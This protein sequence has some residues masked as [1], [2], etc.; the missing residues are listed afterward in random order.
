M[1]EASDAI[2]GLRL[3]IERMSSLIGGWWHLHGKGCT[4]CRAAP[5]SL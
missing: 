5:G 3:I 2:E 4:P 1:G